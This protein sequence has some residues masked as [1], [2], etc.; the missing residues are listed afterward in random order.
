MAEINYDD[1]D[2]TVRIALEISW[3]YTVKPIVDEEKECHNVA[4][5]WTPTDEQIAD[6]MEY[7]ADEC[8]EEVWNESGMDFVEAARNAV[9]RWFIEGRDMD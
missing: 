5:D 6:I 7:V 3:Q 1:G 8:R 4:E 2:K 9:E